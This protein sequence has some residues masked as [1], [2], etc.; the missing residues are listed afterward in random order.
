MTQPKVRLD[1]QGRA[2]IVSLDAPPLNLIDRQMRA[3]LLACIKGAAEHDIDR[4]I[5]TS[6]CRVFV[7]GADAAEFVLPPEAPH[8]NDVLWTLSELPIPTI[9][10]LEG[11]AL[12][13]GC[14]IA[15]ACRARIVGPKAQLGLPEV[16]LGLVPGAGGTQ[17]LPRLV[18]IP[19]A[20]DVIVAGKTLTAAQA[21][22]AGAVTHLSDMPLDY[23]LTMPAEELETLVRPNALVA[24]QSAPDALDNA[25]KSAKRRASG[26]VAPLRAVDLIAA[27]QSL[28]LPQALVAE[29]E[30]FLTLRQSDQARALRHVFFAE[31][32]AQS[33]ARQYPDDGREF[34]TACVVGGGNMGA[35][36]AYT[37]ASAGLT[38]QIIER[39]EASRIQAAANCAALVSAGLS[40]GLLTEGHANAISA[41]MRPVASY[42]DLGQTDLAI[43]AVFENMQVKQ[44]ILTKLEAAVPETCVLATNTSYLDANE[45]AARLHHPER[46]LGLHFFSPAHIMKLLEV[47]RTDSTSQA[48]LGAAFR[49]A[50]KLGKIPVLSGVCEGFIGNRIL[51][52]YREAAEAALLQ[53]AAPSQIDNA[54]REFGM[55]MGP[56]EAQDMS[57][58]DIA[59]ANRHRD[60]HA[61]PGRTVADRLVEDHNRLGR[62]TAGGWYDYVDGKPLGDALAVKLAAELARET[63]IARR[64]LTNP[65]LVKSLVGAMTAEAQT[66][67]D[68]GIAQSSDDID[69]VMVHG[70]GF[71]RWRGGLMFH[72]SNLAGV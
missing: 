71:P 31:R 38:V 47:I 70:Y 54:L 16:K 35:A 33:R 63:G 11:A 9:A 13:G 17:R 3:E 18:G 15:L 36:I 22:E 6:A 14:E 52:R 4:L 12:G 37:L 56:F 32:A 48:T 53:G 65:D 43:E 60:D 39:D 20:L 68:E 62:K 23:A 30:T 7:A 24:P 46:F 55:A 58:L 59:Y 57:G 29:R 66:I 21:Y 1:V 26:Q 45:M 67:L 25:R 28:P 44:E 5:F 61:P 64:E 51:K 8:L 10:V 69:L 19:L 50:R 41:R 34:K 40:R 49:L 72:A 2:G 27:S 42:D